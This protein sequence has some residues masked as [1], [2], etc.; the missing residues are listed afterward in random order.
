MKLKRKKQEVVVT[1]S[2]TPFV[3]YPKFYI[4][5]VG[6]AFSIEHRLTHSFI[7]SVDTEEEL[8]EELGRLMEMPEEELWHFLLFKRHV[9]VNSR[10]GFS[11]QNVD[12]EDW[13]KGAWIYYTSRFYEKHPELLEEVTDLPY[14]L[15]NQIRREQNNKEQA[16]YKARRME[17]ERVENDIKK[18]ESDKDRVVIGDSRASE[19]VAKKKLLKRKK[20]VKM[21]KK[22]GLKLKA[23]V[24]KLS[25]FD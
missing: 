7:S 10:N 12:A 6:G 19:E 23:P 14:D 13:Y 17:A 16:E 20:E 8:V 22:K 2:H 18:R 5:A 21:V 4:K 15:I 9:Y 24:V 1:T 3:H 11:K 25:P